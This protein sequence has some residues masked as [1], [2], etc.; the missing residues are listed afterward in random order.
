MQELTVSI[1]PDGQALVITV[2]GELDLATVPDLEEALRKAEGTDS[3]ELVLDLEG[4]TF[5]DSTGIRAL[6]MAAKRDRDNGERLR[7]RPGKGQVE[8]V[9][10]LTRADELLPLAD[11]SGPA[12]AD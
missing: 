11:D 1:A 8:R 9:L 2:E 5:I 10:K 6:L 4:L 12:D 3:A 7:I